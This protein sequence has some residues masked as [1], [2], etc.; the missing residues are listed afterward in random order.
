MSRFFH[1][2]ADEKV[3]FKKEDIAEIK[4]FDDPGLKLMGFKPKSRI[5][6]YHNIRSSYFIYPDE[7]VKICK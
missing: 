3:I 2:L 5:K 1:P 4:K 7:D 6:P